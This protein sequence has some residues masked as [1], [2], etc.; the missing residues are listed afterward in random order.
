LQIVAHPVIELAKRERQQAGSR[1][2]EHVLVALRREFPEPQSAWHDDPDESGGVR[3]AGGD[4]EEPDTGGD[5]GGGH[6]DE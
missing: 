4:Y 1:S 5:E 2:G 6:H 3:V